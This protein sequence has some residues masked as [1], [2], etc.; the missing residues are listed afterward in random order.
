MGCGVDRDVRGVGL[1]VGVAIRTGLWCGRGHDRVCLV[2]GRG[3]NMGRAELCVV[4]CEGMTIRMVW[5]WE[6][7]EPWKLSWVLSCSVGLL[8]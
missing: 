3:H 6:L 7:L 2:V 1:Y 5:A 4:C 8:L